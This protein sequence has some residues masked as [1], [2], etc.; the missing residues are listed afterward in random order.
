MSDVIFRLE[1]HWGLRLEN[2]DDCA[3]RLAMTLAAL[4]RL[5]PA[6][7]SWKRQA[8]TK[9]DAY[10]PFCAMPPRID[11][12]SKRFENCFWS[13]GVPSD[14]FL[15]GTWNGQDPPYALAV[16]VRAGCSLR[17]QTAPNRFEIQLPPRTKANADLLNSRILKSA[18]VAAVAAW[19]PD[20]GGLSTTDYCYRWERAEPWDGDFRAVNKNC[21]YLPIIRSGWITYLCA[22]YA[23]RIRPP[24]AAEVEPLVTGGSLL[25]ATE[26]TFSPGNRAHDA[27]ADA[28]QDALLLLQSLPGEAMNG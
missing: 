16:L 25:I 9:A 27:V 21:G 15:L 1:L 8:D 17:Y 6:F 23:R 7:S 26:E 20:W 13:P 14:G 18:L 19:N 10:R 5:H 2:A 4:A 28:I 22:D 11:E 3:R 12:L 24:L